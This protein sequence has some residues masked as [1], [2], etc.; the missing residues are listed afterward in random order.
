MPVSNELALITELSNLYP[1]PGIKVGDLEDL[2][3]GDDPF[4]K[5]ERQ[6]SLFRL[7]K[8]VWIPDQSVLVLSD[9]TNLFPGL[10]FLEQSGAAIPRSCLHCDYH[11]DM[12]PISSIY[13]DYP[14]FIPDSPEIKTNFAL[15]GFQF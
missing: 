9:H 2:A 3:C 8:D 11:H 13:D 4:I 12:W 14:D 15:F 7:E 5:V 1:P 6:P 10:V